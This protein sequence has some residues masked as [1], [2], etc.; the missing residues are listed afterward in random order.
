MATL[1]PRAFINATRRRA[2]DQLSDYQV[3]SVRGAGAGAYDVTN[4][5]G[6]TYRV[7]LSSCDCECQW[8]FRKGYCKHLAMAQIARM[9]ERAALAMAVFLGEGK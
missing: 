4:P 2:V 3:V 9:Q 1:L 6:Q 7:S 5:E 8:F